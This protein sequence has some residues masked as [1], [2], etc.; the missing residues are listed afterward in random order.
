MLFF[1]KFFISEIRFV[2]NFLPNCGSI[3]LAQQEFDSSRGPQK[4]PN[5]PRTAGFGGVHADVTLLC[6]LHDVFWVCLVIGLLGCVE[7][8][9]R[10][11]EVKLVS[12]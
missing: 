6:S 10:Q 12:I 5:G 3:G 4:V 1:H 8:S 9:R 11:K 2:L 7:I